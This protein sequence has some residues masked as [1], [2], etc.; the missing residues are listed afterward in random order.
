M[1]TQFDEVCQSAINKWGKDKQMDMVIEECSE[2][3]KTIVK[4]RRYNGNS[5]WRLKAIEEAVDVHIMIRQLIM[6]ISSDAEFD[7][8]L[9]NKMENLKGIIENDDPERGLVK[10]K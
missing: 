8:I 6:M 1:A 7:R 9:T 10:K 5:V 3:I 4:Y 2:L